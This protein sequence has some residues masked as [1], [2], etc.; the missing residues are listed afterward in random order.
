[1]VLEVKRCL[2][3]YRIEAGE[4]KKKRLEKRPLEVNVRTV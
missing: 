3:Q 4:H 1:M 2:N